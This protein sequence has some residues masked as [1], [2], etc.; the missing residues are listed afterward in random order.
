MITLNELEGGHSGSVW[1]LGR[2]ATLGQHAETHQHLRGNRGKEMRKTAGQAGKLSMC[3]HE[4]RLREV[5]S[6]Q[7]C[8]ML[9]RKQIKSR[10]GPIEFN[11]RDH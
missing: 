10:S 5:G 7:W 4:A 6:G 11:C 8:G 1:G 3:Y 9:P 2:E